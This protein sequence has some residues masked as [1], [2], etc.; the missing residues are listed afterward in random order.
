M[1]VL[2]FSF[3]LFVGSSFYPVRK[4]E[5]SAAD[6]TEHVGKKSSS[7]FSLWFKEKPSRA[8]IAKGGGGKPLGV[9]PEKHSKILAQKV[10]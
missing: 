1:G 3:F 6:T 8:S 4:G 2:F 10:Q 7:L 9:Y 5:V